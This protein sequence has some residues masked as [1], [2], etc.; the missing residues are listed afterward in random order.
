MDFGNT[1]NPRIAK[2]SH[3]IQQNYWYLG[4]YLAKRFVKSTGEQILYSNAE[5]RILEESFK[6]SATKFTHVVFL[7]W[8]FTGRIL[9]VFW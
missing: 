7:H 8:I 2:I 1:N 5:W 6:R 9:S 3:A 4:R